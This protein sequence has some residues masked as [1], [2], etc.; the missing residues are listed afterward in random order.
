MKFNPLSVYGNFIE[1]K[2]S[3]SVL[4]YQL[5]DLYAIVASNKPDGYL[6]FLNVLNVISNSL[7]SIR[8]AQF[9]EEK[10]LWYVEVAN[11]EF[12]G[13]YQIGISFYE[14]CVIQDCITDA[15]ERDLAPYKYNP[16]EYI[17]IPEKKGYNNKIKA[18]LINKHDASHKDTK[19]TETE[20]AIKEETPPV[21]DLVSETKEDNKADEP[22]PNT[23]VKEETPNPPKK[24]G[25][26]KKVK[27]TEAD[28]M[29]TTNGATSAQVNL[30]LDCT[31]IKDMAADI[32]VPTFIC[33]AATAMIDNKS[34][35]VIPLP[36]K[37]DQA[38]GDEDG[39]EPEKVPGN[40]MENLSNSGL[41]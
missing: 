9:A 4:S 16:G 3:K 35:K 11:S 23:G 32:D 6:E 15:M 36:E 38:E 41:L 25:R 20:E 19:S 37:F 7:G 31:K 8:F 33:D 29:H 34:D 18:E 2:G 39:K 21:T 13:I 1:L 27:T 26:R 22:N 40:F 14:N 10:N 28:D 17:T 12:V 24:R 30:E 5:K